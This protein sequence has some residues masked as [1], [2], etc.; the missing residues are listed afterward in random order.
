MQPVINNQ[1]GSLK[2]S[3]T[4]FINQLALNLRSEGH[5]I[6]H[7]GFG[8]SPFPVPEPMR[9]ALQENAY[10]KQ[11]ISGYGLPELRKAVAGFFNSEFGY[12]YSFEKIFIGPG[13][14]ELIFQLVYL[15]EGPLMV[16]APSWVSYGPQAKIR[17]KTFIPIPT[18]RKNGYRL[19]AEELEKTCFGL[20]FPQK[21]LIL[22]NP[23]NP[24]GSVHTPEE[25]KDL[26]E[27]CRKHGII[28]ISDEIYALT[29]FGEQPF[30]GIAKYYPEGTITTSGVSKAFS[31]GGW[32][33]GFAMIPD[34]LAKIVP[35]L[36]AFVSETFSCVSAPIQY[37]ALAGFENYD[38]VRKHV[39]RCRDI[40]CAAGHF[41]HQRFTEIGL[42]CPKPQGAFYLFPDFENFKEKLSSSGITTSEKLSRR[43][44]EETGVALLP[45]SDFYMLN[46]FLVVRVASVDYDG[47]QLLKDFPM[48]NKLTPEMFPNLFPKLADAAER[49]EKWLS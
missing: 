29:N 33:L 9:I 4:L 11:Y 12:N 10:R 32:R 46:D 31:A 36:S 26:A 7:L 23:S 13:S 1:I 42:N 30:E 28:V 20:S 40:H 34:E 17:S 43:L 16:P 14:K 38:S 41:L 22:N 5:N 39:E 47:A 19:Q 49:I 24:T 25:L 27:V 8:E 2:E 44:L 15:L 48:K 21:L 6:C 35:P 37:G 45:G 3:A 18:D